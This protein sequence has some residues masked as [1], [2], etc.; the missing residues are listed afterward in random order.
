MFHFV[1]LIDACC[2]CSVI[3]LYFVDNPNVGIIGYR[4]VVVRTIWTTA[5]RKNSSY[6][7]VAIM[8]C[9]DLF[10]TCCASR[11]LL[12][13]TQN[14]ASGLKD[15]DCD[16]V[17]EKVKELCADDSQLAAVEAAAAK[18]SRHRR[19]T[20][21]ELKPSV[22]GLLSGCS[23]LSAPRLLMLGRCSSGDTLRPSIDDDV[24]THCETKRGADGGYT[25]GR[26]WRV[27]SQTLVPVHRSTQ[28]QQQQMA[29]RSAPSTPQLSGTSACGGGLVS[30][31]KLQ[32]LCRSSYGL[33]DPLKQPHLLQSS[34]AA[35]ND[36]VS[37]SGTFLWFLS[38]ILFSNSISEHLNGNKL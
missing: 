5:S 12:R 20:L 26:E 34:E 31:R 7:V 6:C 32:R 2:W 19:S 28:L 9:C 37:S 4:I 16:A 30:N 11:L 38:L 13:P 1:L 3:F 25:T 14:N 24:M 21:P 22:S 10:V 17:N 33:N 15:D 27:A 18:A 36:L 8:K 23:W 29:V 35:T